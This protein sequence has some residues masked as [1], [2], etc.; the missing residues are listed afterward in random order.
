MITVVKFFVNVIHVWKCSQCGSQSK[1]VRMCCGMKTDKHWEQNKYITR[2]L[3]KIGFVAEGHYDGEEDDL[4][5]WWKVKI[6]TEVNPGATRGF[7]LLKPLEKLTEQPQL[8]APPYYREKEVGGGSP[9]LVATPNF[10]GYYT[11]PKDFRK[12]LS[13]Q[14]GVSAIVINHGGNANDIKTWSVGPLTKGDSNE[15]EETSSANA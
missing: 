1:N 11:F 2:T 8:L 10:P 3:R 4:L 13:T 14:R 15:R 5:G 12:Q 9:V 6:L 7:F